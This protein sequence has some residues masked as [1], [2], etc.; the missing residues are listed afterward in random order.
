MGLAAAVLMAL[1]V[2][3]GGVVDVVMPIVLG[4][5][6]A[7]GVAMASILAVGYPS[8]MARGAFES[9]LIFDPALRGS[10]ECGAH[11]AAPGH[12][13]KSADLAGDCPHCGSTVAYED[14][15]ALVDEPSL[16][17]CPYCRRA[18]RVDEVF[19]PVTDK[20]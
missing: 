2:W 19:T 8:Q 13:A 12:E 6:L 17:G 7:L 11:A 10:L 15:V 5:T 9:A 20:R 4:L 14:W 18:C 16:M 3:R 1:A